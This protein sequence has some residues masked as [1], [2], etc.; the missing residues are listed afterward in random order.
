MGDRTRVTLS[1]T[2]GLA[3]VTL[4]QP[5]VNALD[6]PLV[7]ELTDVVADIRR[8]E[9]A[10][11]VI[12]T[13]GPKVFA[14]GGDVKEMLDWD[15]PK[16]VRDSSALGDVCTA[17]A[18]LP[19]PV[20][21]AISGYALGGG[22]ELALAADLRVCATD[23]TLGFPEIHLGVIPGAGG[24]QRL[25]R[26]VGAARAKDLIFSGRTVDGREAA[27]L[28]LAD[29]AVEPAD[30][31]DRARQLVEP[32]LNGPALALRAAK[33]AVDRGLESSLETGLD[34]ERSLFTGL[35]ATE[36]RAAGMASF[37]ADGAGKAVFHGR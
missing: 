37:V 15:Y 4:A 31:P 30:V 33:E 16:A 7:R 36:D 19:M 11:A 12:V 26:L 29:Y 17:L 23:A 20:V 5:P 28:G 25:P 9:E 35:F 22:L 34:L 6:G 27:A 14:A 1:I 10:R 8:S 2:G 32:Y 24:T 13:G 18:R 21:A 3:A